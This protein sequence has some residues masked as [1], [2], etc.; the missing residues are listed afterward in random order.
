MEET[1]KRFNLDE[2]EP[3]SPIT[4]EYV[5]DQVDDLLIY[6][7]YMGNFKIGSKCKHPFRKDRDPSFAVFFGQKSLKLMWKDFGTGES[8]DCFKLVSKLRNVGYGEAIR[9][10]ACDFGLVKGCSIVTKK[11]IQEAREFKEQAQQEYIIDVTPRK[12]TK[13]ELAYWE[14]YCITKEDLKANLIY[15]IDKIWLN[16]KEMHLK[17]GL[18]FAYGFP[19]GKVKIYS[20]LDKENKW[21]GNCSTFTME[22]VYHQ[23]F[24]LDKPII[25]T[26]SRKDRLVLAKIYSN[27]CSCQNESEGAVPKEMDEFFDT[28]PSKYCWFDSDEAGKMAS[29]KLNSRGYKWINVPNEY[30]TEL[31]LKDPSDIVRHF[32]WE[33]GS[34]ILLNSLSKK[35]L[36]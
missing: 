7:Y 18:H 21:F 36:I 4:S 1:E 22:N 27:T 11:Q 29:K 12:M 32:G 26:K 20:P 3:T 19:D 2:H 28:F 35:G 23:G 15:A 9:Q 13:P 6:R 14:Q 30:Y 5:L 10:V 16:K 33:Q 31:G 34:Q 17:G 24:R 8:G 25:I